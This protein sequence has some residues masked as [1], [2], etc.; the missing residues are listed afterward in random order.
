MAFTSQPLPT[1]G[2][3]SAALSAED[4]NIFE[5]AFGKTNDSSHPQAQY[6][7]NSHHDPN[8]FSQSNVGEYPPLVY[9]SRDSNVV[10][11]SSKMNLNGWDFGEKTETQPY[12]NPRLAHANISPPYS[13]S[14]SPD[15]AFRDF[16]NQ[17]TGPSTLQTSNI[18]VDPRL[19]YGQITPPDDNHKDVGEN[20]VTP[21]NP[22]SSTPR[23]KR[24]SS[25]TKRKRAST[26]THNDSKAPLTSKPK[27]IRSR[28][29]KPEDTDIHMTDLPEVEDVQDEKR[30][31]FLERNRVAASKCR[32]KKKEWTSNLEAK[33]RELQT[34]N[35]QQLLMITSLKEELMFLKGEMLNHTECGSPN[36]RNYLAREA[37]AISNGE[38]GYSPDAMARR[39]A[40]NIAE[41]TSGDG[42][43]ARSDG[44]ES[45]RRGSAVSRSTGGA[46][47]EEDEESVIDAEA[48]YA[49]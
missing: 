43:M 24:R 46:E 15:W 10:H 42:E 6:L 14:A 3:F 39:R 17:V 30:Y 13:A 19:Q 7:S 11:E 31:K 16:Q 4:N 12:P 37:K 44:G 29:K 47:S 1:P 48:R 18:G 36:I 26:S 33:A 32:Q 45:D 21:S 28:A 34:E 5:N 22:N 8:Y 49:S 20:P 2:F 40:L 27:A 23:A 41:M 38:S 9:N 35:S 25:A